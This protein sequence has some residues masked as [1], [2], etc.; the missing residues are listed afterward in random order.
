MSRPR[1]FLSG[2]AFSLALAVSAPGSAY[3]QDRDGRLAAAP[4]P[5]RISTEDVVRAWDEAAPDARIVVDELAAAYFRDALDWPEQKAFESEAADVYRALSPIERRRMIER[6]KAR[7]QALPRREQLALRKQD[8]P[9]YYGLTESRLAGLRGPAFVRF[10]T[11][12]ADERALRL[13]EAREAAG[14]TGRRGP[15]RFYAADRAA[16]RPTTAGY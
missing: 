4:E 14:D 12:E 1:P 5:D 7:Y 8:A 11:M 9:S 3:G 15:A 10:Q 13:A 16:T 2:L 6:R